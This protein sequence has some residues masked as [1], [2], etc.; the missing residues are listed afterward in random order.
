M[1][2]GITFLTL[3][4]VYVILI[5][6]DKNWIARLVRSLETISWF[7]LNTIDLYIYIVILM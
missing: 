6:S 1:A 3:G 7:Y 5:R 4:V 2:P